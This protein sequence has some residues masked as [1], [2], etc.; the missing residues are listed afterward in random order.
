MQGGCGFGS[1]ITKLAG[2]SCCVCVAC[3]CMLMRPCA[4]VC[5][6]E[7]GPSL[8]PHN[9]DCRAQRAGG[10]RL[11]KTNKEQKRG[12]G[13]VRACVRACLPASKTRERKWKR[14]KVRQ[15]KA[16]RMKEIDKRRLKK[17]TELQ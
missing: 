6:Q 2:L 3:V 9:T 1:L 8:P 14:E 13:H 4:C 15:I 16:V 12:E 7:K 11:Q 10:A 5:S 17:I